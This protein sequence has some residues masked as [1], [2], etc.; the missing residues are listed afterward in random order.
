MLIHL[1]IRILHSAFC[2]QHSALRQLSRGL[3]KNTATRRGDADGLAFFLLKGRFVITRGHL[4]LRWPRTIAVIASLAF[5]RLAAVSAEDQ[6]VSWTNIVNASVISGSLQKTAGCDGCE[7]AGASSLQ[8]VA[9]GDGFVEFTVGE[10]N[11]LWAAGISHGDSDTTYAD[12]DFAFRFNGAGGADVIE[13][14]I[15]QS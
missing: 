13:N 7:D 3:S 11:T 6:A 10:L 9:A 14:G 15:Y 12:I 1:A 5:L 4:S 8:T 2:I